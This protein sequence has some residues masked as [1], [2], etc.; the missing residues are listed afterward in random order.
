MGNLTPSNTGADQ[1]DNKNYA[2]TQID[3]VEESKFEE[4]E[5]HEESRAHN[6]KRNL[7]WGKC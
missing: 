3:L 5:K 4:N 2:I 7:E 1:F 6:K